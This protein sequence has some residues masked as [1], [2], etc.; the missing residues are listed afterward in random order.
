MPTLVYP[1]AE[2]PVVLPPAKFTS[3]EY[4]AMVDAGFLEGKKVELIDGVIVAMSPAGSEHNQFLILI[5]DLLVPVL[6]KYQLAIQGT[7]TVAE[8][9]VFDPD[10]MLLQR[11]AGGYKHRK[12]EPADAVLVIEAAAS[13]FG[14]DR[15][16]KLPAYAQAGIQEYWIADLDNE[17]LFVHREPAG[18]TYQSVQVLEGEAVVSPLA[19]PDFSLT[20]RQMF[21]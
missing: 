12:I 18:A 17:R 20:I 6:E 2:F 10:V 8:G 5:V 3:K 1:T 7:L 19:A 4:L 11:R 15:T 13:S 16:I 21:E 9:Q 14:N